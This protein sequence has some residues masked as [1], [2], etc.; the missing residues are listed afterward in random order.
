MRHPCNEPKHRR[1]WVLSTLV[2]LFLTAFLLSNNVRAETGDHHRAYVDALDTAMAAQARIAGEMK[3]ISDG[4]VAHFDF[5]QHEHIELLRHARALLHPPIKLAAGE[6]EA[7]IAQAEALL[8]ASESLE[9][10]IAD[11]LRAQALLNSAVSNTLD[12]IASQPDRELTEGGRHELALLALA[13]KNFRSNNTTDTRATLDTAFDK[14]ALL[15]LGNKWQGELAMQRQLI[16]NN[17][18]EAVSGTSKLAQT[19]VAYLAEALQAAYLTAAAE[20]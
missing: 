17:A 11:F 15:P 16:T 7:L 19:K 18:I 12:L 9:L 5:L 20:Q 1:N 10:V 14:V 8:K 4:T 6:R 3:K 13:A 2:L